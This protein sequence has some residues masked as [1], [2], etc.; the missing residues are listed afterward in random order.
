MRRSAGASEALSLALLLA[1]TS[2]LAAE[3]G[4]QD[5]TGVKG[6]GFRAI[7]WKAGVVFASASSDNPSLG[8]TG[9][10]LGF[11]GGLLVDYA[12]SW[13]LSLQLEVDFSQK[14]YSVDGPETD[15]E[16]KVDYW[17]IPLLLKVRK[18]TPGAECNDFCSVLRPYAV[19]GPFVAVE[20][21]CRVEGTVDGTSVDGACRGGTDGDYGDYGLVLGAGV[22]M[23]GD[24]FGWLAIELR[25]SLGLYTID[26]SVDILGARN[27]GLYLVISVQ[28]VSLAVV[29]QS[30]ISPA[31]A[32]DSRSHSIEASE[33]P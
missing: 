31:Y 11:T 23:G 16:V 28:R 15:A 29:D 33:C 1:A 20:N 7:G 24:R 22:E 9:G 26:G 19:V 14:G 25:Y 18:P 12:F 32:D 4:A 21:K 2:L 30:P 8:N 6:H 27:R 13:T 5:S 17:E 10:R 3:A